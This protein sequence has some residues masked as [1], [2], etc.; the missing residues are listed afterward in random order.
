MLLRFS[1]D[2]GNAR[3]YECLFNYAGGIQIVRWNGEFGSFTPLATTGIDSLG[4]PLVSGDVVKATIVGGVISTY[5]NG[6]L[7]ARANNSMFKS[8]QPG[9][10]FFVRP[11]G[12]PALLGITSCSAASQ[13]SP[14]PSSRRRRG[15]RADRMA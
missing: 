7:M 15:R 11:G 8:G 14:A 4:R 2:T 5:I 10:S 3:G 6:A 9:I 12:S 13:S 1:D